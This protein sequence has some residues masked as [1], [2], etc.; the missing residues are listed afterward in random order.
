MIRAVTALA[1]LAILAGVSA[2]C[3]PCR[4]W[5]PPIV[6]NPPPPVVV[7]QDGNPP[8]DGNNPAD[9]KKDKKKKDQVDERFRKLNATIKRD[10]GLPDRPVVE[11]KFNFPAGWNDNDLKELAAFPQLRKLELGQNQNANGSGFKDLTGLQN[12]EYLDT[13]GF[14]ISDEGLK[15][16][17][18][19]KGLKV[20]KAV[21]QKVSP[22]G[23]NEIANL[24]QLEELV[25]TNA[26]NDTAIKAFAKLTNL[27][28]LTIDNSDFGDESAKAFVAL[29][30]LKVLHAYGTRV[31]D[32][33]AAELAKFK[34]LEELKIGY[35]VGDEGVKALA[36]DKT[37]KV[38]SIWNC[39]DVT[40]ASIPALLT[41]TGL[42][43]LEIGAGNRFTPQGKSQLKKAFKNKL[44]D[45]R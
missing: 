36:A 22:A 28:R 21:L 12:L 11:V 27:R 20:F 23:L 17:G 40:D 44:K 8:N 37:L 13:S 18:K 39:T 42:N 41:M 25:A 2:C 45:N 33:G 14:Q 34:Q 10:E 3:C 6:L 26:R 16:I 30:Q 5:G 7:N 19:L 1:S 38:L 29:D 35:R 32:K 9:K 31:T 4:F 15:H 24:D 43:E